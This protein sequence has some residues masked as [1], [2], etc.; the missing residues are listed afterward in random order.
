MTRTPTSLRAITLSLFFASIFLIAAE[1]SRAEEVARTFQVAGHAR[2]H[3]QTDDGSVRVSTGDIKQIE[4][5]VEYTGY[6]LDRDLRVSMSQNGDAV[7]VQAKTSGG[8]WFS[9]GVRHSSIRVEIH[10]PKDADLQI[11]TGDGSVEVDSVSGS[12]DAQSGDG[13]I[14]IQGGRG[15]IRLRSG[16]GHIEARDLDGR[17]DVSTGDGSVNLEGRFDSLNVKTGDGSITA[18]AHT[19]SKV[20]SPWNLHTGDGSVDLELPDGLQANI[21]ASTHDGHISLGIPVTVEGTFSSSQVHG[22]MNGGGQA[23]VV[24]TGDGSIHLNKA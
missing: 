21:D 9:F 3:V 2:V 19:G 14:T 10:M 12:I 22:K 6:K 5:R 20:L 17:V 13:H 8:S 24:R 15:E 23:I 18:R 16:D 7:D 11:Q 4:V 1:P